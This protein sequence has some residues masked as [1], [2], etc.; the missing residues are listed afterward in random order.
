M[1]GDGQRV[2]PHPAPSPATARPPGHESLPEPLSPKA[3]PGPDPARSGQVQSVPGSVALICNTSASSIKGQNVENQAPGPGAWPQ[4]QLAGM[5][6]VD[7]TS[8]RRIISSSPLPP[9]LPMDTAPCPARVSPRQPSRV[10]PKWRWEEWGRVS[11]WGMSGSGACLARAAPPSPLRR[12]LWIFF[13]FTWLG[14]V[15]DRSK[16]SVHNPGGFS[17][18]LVSPAPASLF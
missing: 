9:A 17:R 10:A 5:L 2:Q 13:H 12:L 15:L 4:A 16:R 14:D 7:Q 6:K 11:G 18:L 8:K 3:W 1:L